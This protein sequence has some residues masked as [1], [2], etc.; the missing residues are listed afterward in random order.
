M[1][2]PRVSVIF[3]TYNR[4]QDVE[5]TLGQLRASVGVPYEVFVF[6]NSEEPSD[7]EPGLNETFTF[8][9]KNVGTEARNLGIRR[10]RSPYILMLDDDSHP[11]PTC[12]DAAIRELEALPPQ[13]AGLIAKIIR[14]DGERESSLLP[15][16]FQGCGA[17]FR[18]GALR[19]SRGYPRDFCFFGEEYWLTMELYS[20]G[21]RLERSRVLEICHR[22]SLRARDK[23][24]IFYHLAR[25]NHA[26]WEEFVPRRYLEAVIRDTGRRYE[27]ISA[28]EGVERDFL[29]GLE[30]RLPSPGRARGLDEPTFRRFSLV[31]AMERLGRSGA[32]AGGAVLCGCGKLPSL[33]ADTLA[34]ATGREIQIADFNPGLI[35]KRFGGYR[36]LSP[37]LALGRLGEGAT[38]ILGHSSEV[39]AD[40]WRRWLERQGVPSDAL[41]WIDP[42]QVRL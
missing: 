21:Y 24:R 23:G 41:A 11:L 42:G 18:T 26:T 10:A 32:L 25:N 31:D 17:L 8:L 2:R 6:D 30:E 19:A 34:G 12:V 33:W 39:D 13:V 16:V 38:G 3:P 14:P 9:G 27:L 29:R 22:V 15:T 4:A 1:E 20:L 40:R 7:V 35:G 5:E 36:I 28:K 37:E